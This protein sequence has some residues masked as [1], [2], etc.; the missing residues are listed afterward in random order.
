MQVSITLDLTQKTVDA[1]QILINALDGKDVPKTAAPARPAK[2]QKP[3]TD[4]L[5]DETPADE[6]EPETEIETEKVTMTEVRAEALK[7]SKA[8]KQTILKE[9]F[10]KYD[11]ATKLS[12]I[13]ESNYPALMADLRSA[14]G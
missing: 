14:N 10:A 13:S 11:S 9:I 6:P 3:K 4:P 12:D 2:A 8:G 1:L 7:L 5:Q